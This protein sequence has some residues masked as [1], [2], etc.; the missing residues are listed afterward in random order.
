MKTAKKNPA[1]DFHVRRIGIT[2]ERTKDG[3]RRIQVK[4]KSGVIVGWPLGGRLFSQQVLLPSGFTWPNLALLLVC[5][6]Q[7][8]TAIYIQYDET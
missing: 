5:K 1:D 4:T 7:V 8:T 3:E 2:R 6:G